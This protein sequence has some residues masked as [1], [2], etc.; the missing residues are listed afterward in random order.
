MGHLIFRFADLNIKI[1]LKSIK[2]ISLYLCMYIIDNV[3][4]NHGGFAH[5]IRAQKYF[6]KIRLRG[7]QRMM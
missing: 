6:I 3:T 4:Y 5:N 1:Y 2:H 7:K